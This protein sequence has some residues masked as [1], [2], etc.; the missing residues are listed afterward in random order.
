MRSQLERLIFAA[1]SDI[2]AVG[3]TVFLQAM[4]EVDSD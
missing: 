3:G 1:S 2:A 4:R